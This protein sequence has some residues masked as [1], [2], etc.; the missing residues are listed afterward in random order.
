MMISTQDRSNAKVAAS[1]FKS[2][3]L[4]SKNSVLSYLPIIIR[5]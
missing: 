4:D 2:E 3:L 1:S 5:E